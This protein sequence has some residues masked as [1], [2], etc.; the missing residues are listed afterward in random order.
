MDALASVSFCLIATSGIKAF[1]FSSKKEYKG[2]MAIVGIVTT[3]FFSGLYIGLG[4]LGNKFDISKEVLSDP[5]TNIGTYILSMSSYKLFG[6][7]GQI[8]LGTMTILTCFTTTVGLIVVTSEFFTDIFKRFGY[9]TYVNIFTLTGF[10]MSNF[11]LNTII[12]ISVPILK[13]LYPVTIVIVLTVILN[14]FISL[15]KTGMKFTIILT[16]VISAIDVIGNISDVKLIKIF[17]SLFI[18]GRAGFVW[19][20]IVVF[21]ILLSLVLKDKVR[22]EGFEI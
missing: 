17:M 10:A 4:A 9:R 11:G 13:I 18:G 3:I 22:G 5:N 12:K 15:S 16:A 14:K 1:G 6:R 7:F 2:I 19:I 21:G 20:N 8:F